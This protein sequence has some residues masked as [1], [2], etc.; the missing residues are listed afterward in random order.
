[1][2][3]IV[4]QVLVEQ[5]LAQIVHDIN[6]VDDDIICY[7]RKSPEESTRSE[8]LKLQGKIKNNLEKLEKVI[9]VLDALVVDYPTEVFCLSDMINEIRNHAQS[10]RSDLVLAN[11][12]I[13]LILLTKDMGG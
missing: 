8:L 13:P 6:V 9:M 7:F 2:K 11:D 1:M 12:M 3:P 4:E 10:T 5:K